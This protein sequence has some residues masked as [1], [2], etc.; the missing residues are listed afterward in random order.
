M[1]NVQVDFD[2]KDEGEVA[3]VGYQ[4]IGCRLIFD[5]KAT[6]LTWKVLFF[7]AGH[8]MD[9]PA[10]MTYA[11]VV[12]QESVRIVLLITSLN[13]L[14]VLSAYVHNSYLNAPPRE[15][16]WFKSGK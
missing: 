6:M 11:T 10:D 12:S 2:V 7:A 16:A 4:E 8:M 15:K 13:D 9:T 5:I 3:P 14:Y 1:K